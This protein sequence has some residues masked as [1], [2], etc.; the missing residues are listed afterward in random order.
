MQNDVI[1]A[2]MGFLRVDGKRRRLCALRAFCVRLGRTAIAKT[3]KGACVFFIV[4]GP[5]PL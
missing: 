3:A 4:A 1:N 5:A 2:F